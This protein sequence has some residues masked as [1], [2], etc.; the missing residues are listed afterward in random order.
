MALIFIAIKLGGVSLCVFMYK[1]I[2]NVS[3]PF[4]FEEKRF[5]KKKEYIYVYLCV[6]VLCIDIFKYL[7]IYKKNEL[8]S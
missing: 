5:L 7:N 2:I 1:Y 6:C 3:I 8:F 4:S